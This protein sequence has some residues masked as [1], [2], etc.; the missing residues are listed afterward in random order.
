MSDKE[1]L[2]EKKEIDGKTLTHVYALDSEQKRKE[3]VRLLGGNDGDEYANKHAEELLSQAKN[4]K[5]SLN[6]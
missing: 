1:F 2:I 4:Y 6:A 5:E 3:I